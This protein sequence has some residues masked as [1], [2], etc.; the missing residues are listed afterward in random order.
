MSDERHRTFTCMGVI[1]A[2]HVTGDGPLG[3]AGAAVAHAERLL[4]LWDARF[5][6]FRADSEL[7]ALNGDPRE[8]VPASALM[9]R[10]VRAIVSAARD[11][12]GLVDATLLA[13]LENLG[14]RTHF[15]G[16]GLRLDQALALAPPRA[17]AAGDPRRRWSAVSVD[18]GAGLVLRPPGVLLDSGGLGKGLFADELARLLEGHA[19]F[20]VDC[21][22][23]LR[24]GGRA[25]DVGGESPWDGTILDTFAVARGGV[26]TSGIGRRSWLD[27]D[28]RPAHHLLDP[29]TGRAAFTGVV[30]VTA[31]APTALQAEVLSKAALL[32]GPAAL[33]H[34]LPHG[35]LG[36]L[37]D[38]TV[39]RVAPRVARGPRLMATRHDGRLHI[40]AA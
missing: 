38:G 21:G 36:V 2:F 27:G 16:E 18:E 24:V 31:L 35:G 33:E 17:P 13:D 4:H 9:R 23:D 3:S 10:L 1:C 19:A 20:A 7:S 40:A 29:A 22:G 5:S 8:A 32:A 14:Y 26:A 30:Q 37:D 39:R 11:T 34:R 15:A 25:R 12:D 28:G 6:R